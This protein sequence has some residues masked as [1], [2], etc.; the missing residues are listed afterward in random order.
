MRVVILI[1]RWYHGYTFSSFSDFTRGNLVPPASPMVMA[2]NGSAVGS[3][4]VKMY[5]SADAMIGSSHP[6]TNYGGYYNMT[7][8]TL[9]Y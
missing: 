3:S 4:L 7:V 2:S 6:D 8:G 9:K 5:A 1:E